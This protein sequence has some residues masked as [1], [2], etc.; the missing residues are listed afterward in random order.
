MVPAGTRRDPG[1]ATLG[2]DNP[3]G[4][5]FPGIDQDDCRISRSG[6]V[7]LTIADVVEREHGDDCEQA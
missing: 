3:P 7:S 1:Q 6:C 5:Q 4:Q 2:V